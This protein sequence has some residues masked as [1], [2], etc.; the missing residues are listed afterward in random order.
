MRRISAV[1]G[2]VYLGARAER[3]LTRRL[4]AA[5][6]EARWSRFHHRSAESIYRAAIE[7]Q[8]LILKGCQF[9]GTRADVVP[10][11]YVESL[12]RLQDRVP[13]RP[14]AEIRRTIEHELRCDLGEIFPW[15]ARDPVAAASLAQV[16]EARLP[17]GERVAVKVQYPEIAALVK[18]DLA[19][20]RALLRG[21]GVLE[22]GFDLEPLV[23]ELAR[24]VP[25]ELNFLAE[26]RNAETIAGFFA[27]RS[28]VG[29]PR[30]HWELT[31]RRVLV[32]EFIEGVRV[33]DTDGIRRAGL[34]PERVA[35]TLA[36][37]YCEQI[38][39]RGFFH[40]DPHPGNVLVEAR[41]G[42]EGRVVL[43]DFGLAR[44]LPAQFREGA[45]AC[46]AAA[47]RR[48]A[49]GLAEALLEIG[50]ETRDG[51]PE[52]LHEV[53]GFALEIAAEFREQS[54]AGHSLG[55]QV[56]NR[57]PDAIRRN[58]LVR[59]PT[60]LVLVGRALALLAG[61]NRQLGVRVDLAGILLPHLARAREARRAPQAE[62][63]GFSAG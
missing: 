18:S 40:A 16:H 9:V 15:F 5:E 26:A 8:G 41:P 22:R 45:L 44:E 19:N 35:R 31:T 56:R 49:H 34:D 13:P 4:P 48:D 21:V 53:A 24:V 57:L 11:E 25:R 55:E 32:M 6:A 14:F 3:L 28:D 54:L 60:H 37:L 61:V 46:V 47:L 20:L 2:R 17:S 33:T 1:V 42:G 10:P 38:L 29:V 43:V 58:P 36:E 62:A 7:L 27:G 39:G 52:S 59:V 63:A 12:S 30:V 51:R 23:A 50:F